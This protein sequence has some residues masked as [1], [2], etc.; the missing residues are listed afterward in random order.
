[1][2]QMI[3]PQT[4][5][6]QIT[7]DGW[8]LSPL[9]TPFG[10]AILPTRKLE[11]TAPSLTPQ[12]PKLPASM[13]KQIVSFLIWSNNTYQA[14]AIIHG[15]LNP[16][17]Q[18]SPWLLEV[19]HQT[20]NGMTVNCPT[21]GPEADANI[22]T[23][24]RLQALGYELRLTVHHHCNSP[25]SQSQTDQQDEHGKPAGLHITLGNLNN[26]SLSLHSRIVLRSPGLLEHDDLIYPA[27]TH[28]LSP[29]LADFI[30]VPLQHHTA[31]EP[32]LI[33]AMLA[34]FTHPHNEPFPAEWQDFVQPE[35]PSQN[36]TRIEQVRLIG[37]HPKG[38][39]I[40]NHLASLTPEEQSLAFQGTDQPPAHL[41][42]PWGSIAKKL[43]RPMTDGAYHLCRF[44]LTHYKRK[45]GLGPKEPIPLDDLVSQFIAHD[46]SPVSYPRRHTTPASPMTH[47]YQYPPNL[48]LYH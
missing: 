18:E 48:D 10:P 24:S 46:R 5:L 35:T 19:P 13:W 8:L 47:Q 16:R 17:N 28:Q 44:A 31:Q 14:E 34:F 27:R 11:T 45:P 2:T 36:Y 29:N 12:I 30:E 26:Q 1:M 3:P 15:W 21:S 7:S 20:P 39:Q 32:W 25:A 4:S 23:A 41:R 38:L 9:Q 22:A 6:P 43:R 42:F 33:S 40:Y 37:T